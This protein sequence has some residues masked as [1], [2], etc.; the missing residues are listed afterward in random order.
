MPSIQT[1]PMNDAGQ[2]GLEP[3]LVVDLDGTLTPVD[4]F[5]EA[6]VRMIRKSP[7]SIIMLI[8]RCWEGKASLKS[9]VAQ[10]APISPNS[11]PYRENLLAYLKHEKARGRRIILATAS[12]EVTARSVADHL[13]L[14]DM[15]IASDPRDNLKGEKK[16]ERIR[17]ALGPDFVYA[18]DHAA[19]LPIWR[20]SSAAVLVEVP[21]KLRDDVVSLVPVEAEFRDERRSFKTWVIGLRI[22]QWLKNVLLL[23]PLVTSFDFLDISAVSAAV[24]AIVSFCLCASATYL[25]NDLLDVDNDRAHPRKQQRPIASGAISTLEAIQA[26]FILLV[27]SFL[28]ALCLSQQFAAILGLY[29]VTTSAYSLKLKRHVLL[30]V[31]TLAVLYTV[32]ILAGAVAIGVSVSTWLLAFSMFIFFSL[33]LVKRCSELMMLQEKGENDSAGRDYH[34]GDLV[35]LWPLGA[36]SAMSSVVIFGLFANSFETAQR[37]ASPELLWAVAVSLLYLLSRL[38]IKTVRGE[39]HDDP[40]VFVLRDSTCRLAVLLMSATAIAARYLEFSITS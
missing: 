2:R 17:D 36:A 24:L 12:N 9:F 33:A 14:F 23:V 6:V 5:F 22:H 26:S 38:W 39:M 40:I 8:R 30:D 27:I 15:V 4:T 29:L 32:R 28:L 18:G 21:S 1:S 16:L 35:V 19:D 20:G 13:G 3:P 10:M 31:I 37:Y 25:V 11:V 7:G 34:V